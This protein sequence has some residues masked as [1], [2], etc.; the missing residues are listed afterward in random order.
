MEF[1]YEGYL[2]V[3]QTLPPPSQEWTSPSHPCRTS[4][5]V[6]RPSPLWEMQW[7]PDISAKSVSR[8]R[9]LISTVPGVHYPQS[10]LWDTQSCTEPCLCCHRRMWVYEPQ[11][12]LQ[13]LWA[14]TKPYPNCP[15]SVHVQPHLHTPY[16]GV[17]GHHMLWKEEASIQT[18]SKME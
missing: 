15:M 7:T 18:K 11:T 12:P 9:A 16:Q 10:L 13:N 14:G 3:G 4:E 6:T 2:L 8:V 5:Q 17:N 1:F